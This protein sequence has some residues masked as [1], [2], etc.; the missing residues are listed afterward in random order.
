MTQD[1][2]NEKSPTPEGAGSIMDQQP[3]RYKTFIHKLYSYTVIR[4]HGYSHKIAI[5]AIAG[6]DKNGN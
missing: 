1:P 3:Q 2:I 4:L 6:K 5:W